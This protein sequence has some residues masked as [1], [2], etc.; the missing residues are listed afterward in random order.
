MISTGG[1]RIKTFQAERIARTKDVEEPSIS[2]GVEATQ[3]GGHR[4]LG[5]HS[6]VQSE[7]ER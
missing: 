1:Q 6:G 7:A 5:E 2:A 4:Y 3:L